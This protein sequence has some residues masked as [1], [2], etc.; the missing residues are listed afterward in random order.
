MRHAFKHFTQGQTHRPDTL[1]APQG[2][3][4]MWLLGPGAAVAN[5]DNGGQKCAWSGAGAAPI[6]AHSARRTHQAG[7]VQAGGPAWG[8]QPAVG[9]PPPS[10]TSKPSQGVLTAGGP[11]PTH[12]EASSPQS[13]MV[14]IAPHRPS[15][16][17]LKPPRGTK[18][19]DGA[20]WP[21]CPHWGSMAWV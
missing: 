8:W 9:Q 11:H 4:G 13:S 21:E 15:G 18:S 14:P 16:V 2:S 7:V 1:D 5:E 19:C 20:Q 12:R 17:V 10:Y 6:G 3:R